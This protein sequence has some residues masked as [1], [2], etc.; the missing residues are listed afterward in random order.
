MRRL[1]FAAAILT[2]LVLAPLVPACSSNSASEGD[3]GD[4]GDASAD[5]GTLPIVVAAEDSGN[6]GDA[7]LGT[8]P[9]DAS[10][11]VN[12]ACATTSDCMVAGEVCG[13][14]A[15]GG[16]AASGV[17]VFHDPP[18]GLNG[19]IYSACGCEG[20]NVLYVAPG[21]TS[22]PVANPSPCTDAS[23]ADDAG[24]A[25]TGDAGDG[26]ALDAGVD[27]GDASTSASA[28]CVSSGGSV[29]AIECC[30][31]TASF[32][33]MCAVGACSCAPASSTFTVVCQCPTNEC[34]SAALGR[35][36]ASP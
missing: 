18:T 27:A 4:A 33:D 8:G 9:A 14:G 19:V 35:C 36:V 16:C 15:S 11:D 26:G 1:L 10:G 3:N 13:F 5:Q 6:L 22:A 20:Q 25:G 23:A 32:P 31:G 2:P 24:D 28:G 12:V 17:C 30:T 34:F 21:W 29:E 7:G